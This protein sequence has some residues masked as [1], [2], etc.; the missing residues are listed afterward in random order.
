M[1]ALSSR[2]AVTLVARREILTRVRSKGFKITT[3][4]LLVALV[5]LSVLLSVLGDDDSRA[6]VAVT[7]ATASLSAPLAASGA[8]AGAPVKTRRVADRAAGAAL[9]QDGSVDALLAGTAAAPQVVVKDDL[10]DS[11][12]T[13]LLLLARS[14]ALDRAITAAGGDPQQVNRQVAAAGV[15]VTS[16]EPPKPHADERLALGMIA[17][18]LLYLALLVYGQSVA[19]GVVEEKSSR[20]VE[21]LLSTIRP[22]QLMAGKVLGI[23]LVGL[24]QLALIGT[25]GIVS[26]LATDSLSL[27][28][29]DS[30]GILLWSLVWYLIGYFSFALLFAAGGALVSRQEDVGSVV[31]PMMMLIIVPYVIG[32]S[33]LP[34]EPESGLLEILSILPL[35]GT[36]VMPMRIAAGVA[37]VWEI[38]LAVGLSLAAIALFVRLAGRV[39]GNAVMRT[40]ARVRIGEVLVG[41][42]TAA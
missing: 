34:A 26:A 5:A 29:G 24:F 3:G 37:P 9:V 21:L 8:A 19:Q 22:W 23:G 35:A 11:L 39:Y 36:V 14:Q 2:R 30:V 13:A 17:G 27:P 32:I 10:D 28:A 40:G 15:R 42:R 16:L 1:S 41:R 25:A 38:L 20:V 6:T 18:V 4:I 33:V 7:P 31:S 12:R